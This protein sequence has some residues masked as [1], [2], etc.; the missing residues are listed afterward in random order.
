MAQNS[1]RDSRPPRIGVTGAANRLSPSWLAIRTCVRLSGGEPLRI[2]VDRRVDAAELDAI[3]ISGGD[4]I[5]PGL[6]GSDE[7]PR[8]EYDHDRDELEQEYVR[9]GLQAGLPLSKFLDW[10]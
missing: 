4:D 7:L 8:K 10:K 6:Y 9:F 5:H 1:G 2:N 3:I